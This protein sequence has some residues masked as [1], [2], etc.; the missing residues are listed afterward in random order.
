[1]DRQADRQM[2]K[3]RQTEIDRDRD[4]ETERRK[5]FKTGSM[6]LIID[7]TLNLA[8]GFQGG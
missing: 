2:E 7:R 3:Q 5:I 8:P 6:R 1:M 4:R